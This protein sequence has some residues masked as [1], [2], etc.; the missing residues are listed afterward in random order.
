MTAFV[1][2]QLLMHKQKVQHQNS[3]LQNTKYGH[4]TTSQHKLKLSL[5]KH[6][7]TQT[8]CGVQSL[9]L[10]ELWASFSVCF[11]LGERALSTL[12]TEGCVGPTAALD[13]VVAL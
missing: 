8:L 7:G 1:Q 4:A 13:T 9:A 5:F 2:A 10:N 12:Q 6:S 11:T 3:L